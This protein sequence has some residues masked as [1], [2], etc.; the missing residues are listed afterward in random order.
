MASQSRKHRGYRTQKVLAEWFARHGWRYAESTGA[1]RAGSDITGMPGL[2]PEVKAR[3]AFEPVAWLKQAA[4]DR[5]G[6]PFVVFRPN[7]MGEQSV[8]KWGMLFTVEHG[9][10]LL[11]LAG[12]G[13][14]PPQETDDG[15]QDHGKEGEDDD[16]LDAVLGPAADLT[17][18][19]APK[20][21][22]EE[23]NPDR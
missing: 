4:L 8:G 6:V 20:R 15:P 5:D 13:D 16:A 19:H 7:G 23:T 22:P 10:Q 2:S 21:T 14:P 11:R 9:T 12:F 18:T 3:R 17:A 1:G